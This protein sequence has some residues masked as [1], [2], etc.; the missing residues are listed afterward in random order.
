[1]KF[2]ENIEKDYDNRILFLIRNKDELANG[3]A[4]K[5]RKVEDDLKT[6][7]SSKTSYKRKWIEL[8]DENEKKKLYLKCLMDIVEKQRIMYL[9]MEN[10]C[11]SKLEQIKELE[12]KIQ[13]C[14]KDEK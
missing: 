12:L 13:N 8:R 5:L 7:G 2:L 6:L 1:M 3:L 14:K 10:Q 4:D 9:L 11:E